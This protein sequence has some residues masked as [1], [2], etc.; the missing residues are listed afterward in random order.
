MIKRFIKTAI[1][2][3]LGYYATQKATAHLKLLKVRADAKSEM[4]RLEALMKEAFNSDL[5]D[6]ERGD[7]FDS[8]FDQHKRFQRIYDKT[9]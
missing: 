3:A 7:L 5:S 1:V 8:Y 6:K 9:F 4:D 2:V